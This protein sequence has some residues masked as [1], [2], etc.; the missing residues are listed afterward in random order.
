MPTFSEPQQFLLQNWTDARLLED[1]MEKVRREYNG[2]LDRVLEQVAAKHG[3]LDYSK[4]RIKDGWIH[5]GKDKWGKGSEPSGFYIED[6]RLDDLTSAEKERPWKCVW[7]VEPDIDEKEAERQLRE[8]GSKEKEPPDLKWEGNKWGWTLWCSLEQS[9]K[10]L[11]ELLV[12]NNARG[13]IDCMVAHFEWLTKFTPIVDE[14]LMA[15]KRRRK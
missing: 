5:V 7:F 10:E 6:L 2:I 1:E 12:K 11:L 4:K 8:A 3:A 9:N 14:I 13:F 15:G